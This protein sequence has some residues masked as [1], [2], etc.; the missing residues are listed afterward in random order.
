MI[1]QVVLCFQRSFYQRRGLF[2]ENMIYLL[3][4]SLKDTKSQTLHNAGLV[5]ECN[6]FELTIE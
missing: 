6:C 3:I 2:K 5:S 4:R 1:I